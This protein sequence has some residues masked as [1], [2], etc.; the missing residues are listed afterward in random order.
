MVGDDISS[1]PVLSFGLWDGRIGFLA[2]AVGLVR[3]DLCYEL[4]RLVTSA[5][6]A[7]IIRHGDVCVA[8]NLERECQSPGLSTVDNSGAVRA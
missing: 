6:A 7:W 5:R 1:H 3:C 4:C 2:H 8:P